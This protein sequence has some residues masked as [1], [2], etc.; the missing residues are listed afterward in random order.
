MFT[1]D[2][3]SNL[4][5]N[6]GWWHKLE[7]QCSAV[8]GLFKY[9]WLVLF[10]TVSESFC[11][12]GRCETAVICVRG[13]VR[14]DHLNTLRQA[15][16]GT[17]GKRDDKV[18]VCVYFRLCVHVLWLRKQSLKISLYYFKYMDGWTRSRPGVPKLFHSVPPSSIGEHSEPPL[19]AL[20]PRLFRWAQAVHDT[21]CSH[22]SCWWREH[23]AGLMLISCNSIHF[24]MYNV[25]SCDIWVTQTLPQN[26]W[27]KKHS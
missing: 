14:H 18:S 5:T 22:S 17:A 7:L 24:A 8:K 4:I 27:G 10:N 23:L 11:S 16:A 20:E 6:Q 19:A 9:V 1:D 12:G 13:N 2:E 3:H 26:L 15:Q 25:Y 21:N